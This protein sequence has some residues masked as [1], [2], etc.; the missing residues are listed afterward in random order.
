MAQLLSPVGGAALG[1]A[2]LVGVAV[3]AVLLRVLDDGD[4]PDPGPETGTTRG[5][6]ES[7]VAEL[8][9][10]LG[11]E[12]ERAPVRRAVETLQEAV[13]AVADE[14]DV[15]GEEPAA[16]ASAV[17]RAAR[18]GDLASGDGTEPAGSAPPG[19]IDPDDGDDGHDP[20]AAAARAVDRNRS[21][22][23][24]D[25]RRL[26]SYLSTEDVDEATLRQTLDAVLADVE[27]MAALESALVDLPDDPEAAAARLSEA[28]AEG[29]RAAG[30]RRA[31]ELLDGVLADRRSCREARDR[32]ASAGVDICTAAEGAGAR[33]E[34]ETT[35]ERLDSLAGALRRGDLSF[36]SDDEAVR[37]AVRAAAPESRLA[38]ALVEVFEGDAEDP[39]ATVERV[40]ETLDEA[41]RTQAKL[42][43]VTPAAVERL[44]ESVRS[45]LDGH[46]VVR[47]AIRE[48]VEEL[49]NT[50]T[51]DDPDPLLSYAAR[52][53]LRF[54]ERT[55]VPRLES[56]TDEDGTTDAEATVETV[57]ARRDEMRSSLP[58]RY[59]DVNHE[60][61]I[62]LLDTAADVVADAEAALAD[63]DPERAAGMATATDAFLDAV[64]KLY[65]RDAYYTLLRRLRA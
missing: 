53:E 23:S 60:I 36:G 7:F 40:L 6:E 45:S 51:R 8:A 48:R 65:R 56:D 64:E 57:G 5:T 59:D 33:L 41:E 3:G 25:A 28:T 4:A 2:L 61:P 26:V 16:R 52:R 15:P 46:G 21:F 1:V 54:Y 24:R 27:E 39:G 12:A 37:R 11:V 30:V 49:A 29:D 42:E 50:A 34:G 18:R 62:H 22:R 31:G 55:L 10:D 43:G 63:G 19:E 35:A 13:A 20:V 58:R 14:A 47:E 9:D 32:L 44:A 17:R 38:T